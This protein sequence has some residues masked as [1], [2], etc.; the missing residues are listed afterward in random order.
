LESSKER[1]EEKMNINFDAIKDQDLTIRDLQKMEKSI[2]NMQG[3]KHSF[4]A[5]ERFENSDLFVMSS[6]DE[7][8]FDF[9]ANHGSGFLCPATAQELV[10]ELK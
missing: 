3:T 5:H 7:L 2:I 6:I 10:E 1:G 9:Q 8:P 4:T